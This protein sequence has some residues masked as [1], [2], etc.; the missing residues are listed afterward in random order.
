MVYLWDRADL[1]CPGFIKLVVE[2]QHSGTWQERG[3]NLEADLALCHCEYFLVG[4]S[5]MR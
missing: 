1:E 5:F 2:R 4:I 3:S